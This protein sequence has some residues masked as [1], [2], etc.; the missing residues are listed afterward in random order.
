MLQISLLDSFVY[1]SSSADKYEVQMSY[2][3]RRKL[4]D[5]QPSWNAYLEILNMAEGMLIEKKATPFPSPC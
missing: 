4:Q 1:S 2:D 5:I 3:F